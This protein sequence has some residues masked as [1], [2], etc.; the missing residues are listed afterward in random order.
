MRKGT[1]IKISANWSDNWGL[2]YSW[3]E[4]DGTDSNVNQSYTALNARSDWNWTNFT[5]DT[6]SFVHGD[7][8]VRIYVNDSSNLENVTGIWNFSIDD[9]APSWSHP[10]QNVTNNTAVNGALIKIAVNWT[11]GGLGWAWYET[12][13]SGTNTNASTSYLNF[14]GHR[15]A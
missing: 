4:T 12:N 5:I 13:S 2:N 9:S 3:F 8:Y 10:D 6:S 7:F 1:L 14:S 11:N 15:H